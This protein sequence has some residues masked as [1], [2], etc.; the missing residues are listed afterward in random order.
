MA[1]R[2][3]RDVIKERT[4]YSE[5]NYTKEELNE[6]IEDEQNIAYENDRRERGLRPRT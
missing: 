4:I 2:D 1:E 6:I 5:N 3:T